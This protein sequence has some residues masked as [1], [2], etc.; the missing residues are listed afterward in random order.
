MDSCTSIYLTKFD[1]LSLI[2]K[3]K[4]CKFDKTSFECKQFVF[5]HGNLMIFCSWVVVFQY[6]SILLAIIKYNYFQ[7]LV[8]FR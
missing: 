7:G 6:K 1:N 8:G 2:F 5:E 4:K 3:C